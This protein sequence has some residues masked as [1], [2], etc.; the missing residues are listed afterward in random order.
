MTAY[1]IKRVRLTDKSLNK[2]IHTL[3]GNGYN[4]HQIS[5]YKR[6]GPSVYLQIHS[7]LLQ[8]CCIK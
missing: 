2:A 5:I 6:P 3:L 4:M 1:G 8:T 7:A